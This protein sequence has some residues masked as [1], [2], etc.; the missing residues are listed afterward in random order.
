MKLQAYYAFRAHWHKKNAYRG[1]YI[2][3]CPIERFQ[4]GSCRSGFH[5]P[6]NDQTIISTWRSCELGVVRAKLRPPLE[7]QHGKKEKVTWSLTIATKVTIIFTYRSC[8]YIASSWD[9]VV[10][11]LTGCEPTTQCFSSIYDRGNRFISSNLWSLAPSTF[12]TSF[13]GPT[14]S[15]IQSVPWVLS[16]GV[17]RPGRGADQSPLSSVEKICVAVLPFPVVSGSL[18][19]RHGASSGC[20]WRN[21]LPMYIE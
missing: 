16:P 6:A 7:M 3:V 21:G 8:I 19:P 9:G 20:G 14:Q 13:R 5:F 2:I 15:A 12:I 1:D 17:S 11:M 18:S 10:G 4:V